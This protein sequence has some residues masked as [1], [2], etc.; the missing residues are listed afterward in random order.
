MRSFRQHLKEKMKD[1]RFRKLYDEE[2]QLAELALKILD[3]REHL[4]LSQIEAA[5]RAKVTQQ[6]LSKIE[7]G[8]NCN[9]ATFLKV[10]NALGLKVDLEFHKLAD[11]G[12]KAARA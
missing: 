6:Q 2:K 5:K 10:C 9:I 4:G 1:V 3:T 7:N 11:W 8:V 12:R